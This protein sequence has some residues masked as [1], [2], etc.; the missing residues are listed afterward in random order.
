M[1]EWKFALKPFSNIK[2][3]D[4]FIK[5][6][7]FIIVAVLS[8]IVLIIV[9]SF[10]NNENQT[11]TQNY[12]DYIEKKIETLLKSV[13]GTGRVKVLVTI[14]GTSEEIVLKNVETSVINGVKTVIESVVLVGGKPY[15]IKTNNPKIVGIV[16]VCDGANDISVKQAILQ[17]VLATLEVNADNVK[18]LKMK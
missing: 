9:F 6:N 3:N 1:K 7:K 5:K 14:D 10:F 13:Q 2:E 15:V 8:V 12:S 11:T 18:I 17:T 16:I 4:S